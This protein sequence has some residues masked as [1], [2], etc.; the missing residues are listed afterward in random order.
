[1]FDDKTLC[2]SSPKQSMI[3]LQIYVYKEETVSHKQCIERY[4]KYSRLGI[5]VYLCV[6][7]NGKTD[8]TNAECETS[9]N[10]YKR[11]HFPHFIIYIWW[12]GFCKTVWHQM[13]SLLDT[14]VMFFPSI[15]C[16]LIWNC[17]P[18]S[19]PRICGFFFF[20]KMSNSLAM[21]IFVI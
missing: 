8:L 7:N 14:V 4:R 1:M 12:F 16:D 18:V 6:W 17:V 3:F 19:K 13:R 20:G 9:A 15:L 5:E 11:G 2:L 10:S 21:L